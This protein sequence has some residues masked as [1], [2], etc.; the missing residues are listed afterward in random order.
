MARRKKAT[1]KRSKKSSRK[2]RKASTKRKTKK[3]ATRKASARRGASK[4]VRAKSTKK[5]AKPARRKAAKRTA[6][7]SAKREET[8]EGNYTASRKFLKDQ[9]SFVEKNR[10][11]IPEMGREAE[12][13]LDGPEGAELIRAEDEA[14]GHA[15]L[16][17]S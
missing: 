8:G 6:K 10:E 4:S 7:R 9:S 2:T 1:A 5:R 12:E 14:R 15:H 3:K 13:S 11:K 17:G 16:S